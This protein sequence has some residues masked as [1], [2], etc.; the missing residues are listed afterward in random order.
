MLDLSIWAALAY[1]CLKS[2]HLAYGLIL[3]HDDAGEPYRPVVF[4]ALVARHGR[5]LPLSA[6]LLIWQERKKR[7]LNLVQVIP[8][9]RSIAFVHKANAYAIAPLFHV[10]EMPN[11][12]AGWGHLKSVA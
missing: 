7:L 1:D 3:A 5:N 6:Q 10:P 8:L 11:R 12:F 9:V 2:W 4:G